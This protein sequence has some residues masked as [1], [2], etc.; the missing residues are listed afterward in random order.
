MYNAEYIWDRS[1]WIKDPSTGKRKRIEN[2]ESEWIINQIEHLRIVPADLWQ[3]VQHRL[4]D[5][6]NRT[7]MARQTQ[8]RNA[9]IGRGPKYLLSGIL[10][11]GTCGG[12]YVMVNR[13]YYGCAAHKDRGNS[14]CTNHHMVARP[15]AERKLLAGIRQELLSE[16]NY[17]IFEKEVRQL[18][19]QQQ[20][21]KAGKQREAAQ[22]KRERDNIID[23]I[24]QGIIT[25]GT[26][27]ALG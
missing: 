17:R 3:T 5:V 21:D 9:R 1:K 25:P 2:P 13:N 6:R 4:Q 16:E 7:A 8:H 11:C 27:K 19:K 15:L 20:P 18:L 24:R 23:A 10:V 14:V 22:A 12:N 26:K